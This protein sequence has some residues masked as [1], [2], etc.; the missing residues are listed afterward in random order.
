M[1]MNMHKLSQLRQHHVDSEEKFMNQKERLYRDQPPGEAA[2]PKPK[3]GI[4]YILLAW[5]LGIFGVHNFYAGY[6]W[7]GAFQLLLTLISWLMLFIP[8]LFV[9][10]WVFLELMFENAAAD[11][12]PFKGNKSVILGLRIAVILWLA[13][14]VYYGDHYW[15]QQYRGLGKNQV[16]VEVEN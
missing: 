9:V 15:E 14:A 12:L 2:Q 3:S 11:G 5:V 8:L 13:A 1:R 16:V 4:I 6:Y 7:R 10:I